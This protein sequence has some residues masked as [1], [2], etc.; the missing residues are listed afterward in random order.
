[1]SSTDP[2]SVIRSYKPADRFEEALP[3]GSGR[4]G[5]M[6]YGGVGREK[7][8]LNYCELWTGHPRDENRECAEYFREARRL[9]LDG[10]PDEAEKIIEK[11]IASADVQSY[12]PAGNIII[13]RSAD[14]AAGYSITLYLDTA[15]ADVSY[16]A[17][18]A[19]YDNTY[20]TPYGRDCLVIRI[21]S[22]K[23]ASVGFHLT[24]E[25]PLKRGAGHTDSTCYLDCECAPDSS[26]NRA[27]RHDGNASSDDAERGI[28]FRTAVTVLSD[29]GSVVYE[30]GGVTV[31]G[32]DCVTVAAAIESSFNG[33]KKHPFLDGKEYKNAV[34]EKLASVTGSGFDETYAG[35]IR[36]F[37][38]LY[39][40]VS[41]GLD[42]CD[43]SELATAERLERFQTDKSDVGLY[44]LLFDFGRYLLICGSAEN[45]QPLNL[46]GIWNEQLSPPWRSDYTVNI[47][48]EMNYWPALTCDLRETQK[49][50][51]RMI[52]QLCERGRETAEKY[53]GARGFCVHHNTDL[54]R[55]TQPVSGR[56]VWLFWPL[57]G[58]W[59]CRHLFD[60]YEY[61]NDVGF[62]RD[63]VY[64]V[65]LEACRF[66]L[67][68]LIRDKDGYLIFCP[69]TSPENVYL[70]EGGV[71]SIDVT[72]TMTMSI[73]RELFENT[74]NAAE[75]IGAADPELD[76]IKTSFKELLPI[77]VG[78]DGRINEWYRELPEAE[79][80]HRHLSH[81]YGLY[82]GRLITPEKTPELAEAA[83][84]S[85]DVRGDEGTGWSL[86]WKINLRARLYDGDRALDLV[87]MM[88]RPAVGSVG[89]VYPNM[90]DA[91]PP[92]QIDGNFGAAAGIAEML[93]QSDGETIKLLPAL[94]RSWKT[95]FVTGLRANGGAKVDIYWENGKITRYKITGGAPRNVVPCR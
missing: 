15:T 55:A 5:A 6:I 16:E 49:P 64:P 42:G 32:A 80:G 70:Y 39:S 77:K 62:L 47:N 12:Q 63:T 56:A 84:K 41:F 4:L 52:T 19:R 26:N 89:G 21:K 81:L 78:G 14:K 51:D 43:R 3:L 73:I 88:L 46:Q 65:M 31:S 11:Y 79:P 74:L 85:L 57:A 29:G 38:G 7:I 92:F 87:N 53:Y 94:P 45:G 76:G 71:C 86:G 61:S 20:F 25:S 82:P 67:D 54:W 30:D 13:E 58:G 90:F 44:R 33:Y 17:E 95:G 69:S 34:E 50:L 91:H 23:K 24:L 9:T 40:R 93:M 10:K 60:E 66:F 2:G 68:L 28:L 59:L 83:K 18:G 48:T 1:M 72:S 36:A 75:I 37:R 27:P 35:H 8:S 22:D